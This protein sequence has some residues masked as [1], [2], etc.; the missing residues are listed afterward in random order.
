[1]NLSSLKNRDSIDTAHYIKFQDVNQSET[2]STLGSFNSPV[3]TIVRS[4]IRW[5]NQMPRLRIW[6]I[7]KLVNKRK[8]I[9]DFRINEAFQ[10][11]AVGNSAYQ[12]GERKCRFIFSTHYKRALCSTS[13]ESGKDL[14]TSLKVPP[15]RSKFAR[16]GN[17]EQGIR[18][19]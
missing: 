8:T 15:S 5:G 11:G 4:R 18:Y 17:S 14:P 9:V 1:M 13:N 2:C 12:T 16:C 3:S 10:I 7:P 6:D 19:P